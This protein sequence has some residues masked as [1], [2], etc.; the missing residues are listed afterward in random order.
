MPSQLDA[1]LNSVIDRLTVPGGPLATVWGKRYGRPMP[2]IE[3][4]PPSLA[5]LF[6]HFCAEH[7]E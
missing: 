1:E 4:A 6:A 5:A 7:G 2:M 3:Q